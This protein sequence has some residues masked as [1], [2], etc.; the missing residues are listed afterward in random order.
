MP[1]SRLLAAKASTKATAGGF[2][3]CTPE[4]T[5]SHLKQCLSECQRAK[6]GDRSRTAGRRCAPTAKGGAAATR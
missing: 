1:W 6:D 4:A 3:P 5:E 2:A